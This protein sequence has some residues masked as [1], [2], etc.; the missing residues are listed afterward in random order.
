MD[1]ELAICGVVLSIFAAAQSLA[2]TTA[3]KL[4]AEQRLMIKEYV[5]REKVKPAVVIKDLSVGTALTTDVR[6]LAAPPDW[7]PLFS[8]YQYFYS[9]NRVVLVDPPSRRVIQII[10]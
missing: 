7:G 9:G 1:R 3:N 6:L 2:Q 8:T 4:S 5:I 10:E